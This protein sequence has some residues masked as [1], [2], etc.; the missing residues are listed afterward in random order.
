MAGEKP[1]IDCPQ[2]QEEIEEA[3]LAL[4]PEPTELE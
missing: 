2:C 3:D 1:T 4:V